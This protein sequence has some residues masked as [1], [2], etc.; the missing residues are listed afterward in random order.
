MLNFF[1]FFVI[2][3][4]QVVAITISQFF[5]NTGLGRHTRRRW[6]WVKLPSSLI[7]CKESGVI[8][9]N[10]RDVCVCVCEKER[11]RERE[12]IHGIQKT[13]KLYI[14]KEQEQKMSQRLQRER[15]DA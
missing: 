15:E 12:I 10:E 1:F 11:E 9:C 13:R 6:S 5:V 8:L 14:N 2:R 3:T 4:V 7:P